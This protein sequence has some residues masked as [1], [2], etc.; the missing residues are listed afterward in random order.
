[1]NSGRQKSSVQPGDD[2]EEVEITGE[3][4]LGLQV[5]EG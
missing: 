5:K 3:L 1:M 2:K 4:N